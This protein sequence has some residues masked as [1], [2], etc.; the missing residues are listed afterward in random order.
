MNKFVPLLLFKKNYFWARH[1]Q[2]MTIIEAAV[3]A[4]PGFLL[5]LTFLLI[6]I[7]GIWQKKIAIKLYIFL[8]NKTIADLL[9]CTAVIGIGVF[10]KSKNLLQCFVIIKSIYLF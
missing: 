2:K 6:S 7:F 1:R 9:S 3:I 4:G 8:T 5:N 10:F